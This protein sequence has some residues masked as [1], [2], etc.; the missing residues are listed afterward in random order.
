[1]AKLANLAKLNPNRLPTNQL[2][3]EK[4]TTNITKFTTFTNMD[5]EKIDLEIETMTV[6]PSS[7]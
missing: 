5:A 2:V 7:T 1:M 6:V 4:C 3:N